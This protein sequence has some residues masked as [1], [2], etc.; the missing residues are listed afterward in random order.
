MSNEQKFTIP[1]TFQPF[2]YKHLICFCE[3][4]SFVKYPLFSQCSSGAERGQLTPPAA[5][6]RR[7][8]SSPPPPPPELNKKREQMM[9]MEETRE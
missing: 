6:G 3:S 9:K 2:Y 1:E 7:G 5:Q 4:N 8:G